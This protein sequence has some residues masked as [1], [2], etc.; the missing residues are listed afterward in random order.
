MIRP[1]GLV[2]SYR[3]DTGRVKGARGSE[4]QPPTLPPPPCCTRRLFFPRVFFVCLTH[5]QTLLYVSVNAA[6]VRVAGNVL[7][8][9]SYTCMYAE[10]YVLEFRVQK[11]GTKISLAWW[12][13]FVFSKTLVGSAQEF[14]KTSRVGP[15]DPT[16]PDPRDLT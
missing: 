6:F 9:L 16:R 7:V 3:N 14:F 2:R 10:Y 4:C 13:D 1:A 5:L 8:R 15:D 12:C 11:T